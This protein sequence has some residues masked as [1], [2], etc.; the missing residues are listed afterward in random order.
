MKN[1]FTIILLLFA[2]TCFSQ[3]PDSY[4]NNANGLT[5]DELKAALH[6]IIKNHTTYSYTSSSTDVWDILKESDRDPNNADNVIL[7]YTGWSVNAAQEWNE[8]AGWSREHVWAKSRG[9]FGTTPPAGTD[10]HHLRPADISVNSARNNRWFNYCNLEYYDAGIPTGCYTCSTDWFWQPRDE[11]KGDIARMIFYMDTRYE[12]DNAEPNLEVIDY[13]PSDDNTKEPI[14]AKLN[15][16]LDW[17][18]EDPVDDFERNRNNV[19]YSYQH[20]RNPFVDHPEFVNMMYNIPNSAPVIK[21]QEFTIAENSTLGTVVDTILA[22]DP[23]YNNITFSILSENKDDA[24]AINA[25]SGILTVNNS[26]ALDYEITPSFTLNLEVS[27]AS[28]ASNATITI[29]IESLTGLIPIASNSDIKIYPNPVTRILYMDIPDDYTFDIYSIIGEKM[30][31]TESKQI[32]VHDLNSGVYFVLIK[33]ELGE[34]VK[35]IKFLKK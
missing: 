3:I 25:S 26:D 15:A 17:N 23:D 6:N 5:G 30:Y 9:N 33:D 19:V 28:L 7:I 32:D 20:N 27:D 2:I 11:I 34:G 31:T 21:D 10:A 18:S 14:H 4:Y 13:I 24:F 12:G 22:S 16:L 29:N 8:G 1:Q 35:S